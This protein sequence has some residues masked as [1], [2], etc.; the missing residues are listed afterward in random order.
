MSKIDKYL[1]LDIIPGDRDVNYR[2]CRREMRGGPSSDSSIGEFINTGALDRG[3][4]SGFFTPAHRRTPLAQSWRVLESICGEW[5][6]R[7]FL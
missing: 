5:Y 7:K 6:G 3:L 1:L 4:R 2:H